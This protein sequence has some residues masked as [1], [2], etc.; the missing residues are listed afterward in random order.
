M[1]EKKHKD[2]ELRS[3]E[4]Q[5]IMN[6]VPPAILRY[7]I[8]VLTGI[9]LLL[10][11]GSAFFSYPETIEAELTLTSNN[12]PAYIQSKEGGRLEQLFVINNQPVMEG[13]ALAVIENAARTEDMLQLRERLHM[14]RANGSRTE[15]IGELFFRHLPQLGDVQPAY[16][17]C[18][19]AWNNYLQ[20]MQGSRLYET[21]LI[22]AVAQLSTA[23]N[24]WE[25]AYLPISPIKGEIAF[26][27]LWKVNQYV[28]TGETMFVIVPDGNFTPVGKALLPMR[29]SGKAKL[30]QR[31][32]V[33]LNGFPEQEYGF[34]EGKV[35]SISPVPDENGN[36]V[37]EITFPNHL[38]TNTNKQLPVMKI[39]TGKVE[40]VIEEHNVLERLLN[41]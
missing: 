19:V 9:I 33:R 37:L 31:A 8:G 35:A 27:Q 20:K 18:L 24:E 2:I 34:L 29:G 22:N 38:L 32:I 13:E 5:E 15:R 25:M 39:M 12:P 40:I 36:F 7:G 17:S 10:V 1:E 28:S 6:K 16:S 3:E 41:F 11:A 26:M 23:I 4:V 30:G 14:W 21:E